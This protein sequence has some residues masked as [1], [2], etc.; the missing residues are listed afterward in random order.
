MVIGPIVLKLGRGVTLMG[1]WPERCFG[2]AASWPD[3]SG[4]R[5]RALKGLSLG[6]LPEQV[7]FVQARPDASTTIFLYA[8][9]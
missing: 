9:K 8:Q 7:K 4:K 2:T 1:A 6:V 5:V 3:C